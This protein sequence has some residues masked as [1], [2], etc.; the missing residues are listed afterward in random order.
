MLSSCR[1]FSPHEAEEKERLKKMSK[2]ENKI[3]IRFLGRKKIIGKQCN[4][5]LIKKNQLK[6]KG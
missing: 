1:I 3:M 5:I 6:L 4:C 2:L